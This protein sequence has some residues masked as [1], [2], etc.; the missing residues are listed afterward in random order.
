[1]D[2]HQS[3]RPANGDSDGR[4]SLP[5]R[6][7]AVLA[8]LPK[9]LRIIGGVLLVACGLVGFLPVLGFW[10]VPLGLL[11]LSIDIPWLKP[12]WKRLEALSL[13]LRDRVVR[14]K[15]WRIGE[16][17]V[18]GFGDDRVMSMAAAIAF[19]T[20]FSLAPTLLLVSWIAGVAFG[21][22]ESQQAIIREVGGLIG[23]EGVAR[24]E[25]I[26]R[27]TADQ[28][29]STLVANII[30]IVLLVF[31]ATTVFVEVNTSLNVI[32]RQ[33]GTLPMGIVELLKTRL[34]SFS[35]ILAF[36]FL[37]LVSLAV[38]AALSAASNYIIGID[39][40]F[41]YMLEGINILVSLVITFVMFAMMYRILPTVRVPWRHVWMAALATAILFNFGKT[42]IGFY[43]GQSNVASTYG[44][45]S[46][47]ILILLWVYYSVVIF[48]AGAEFA[49]AYAVVTASDAPIGTNKGRPGD[50]D[51]KLR[52]SLG[53]Y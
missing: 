16:A 10:M 27:T 48:L 26:M 9:P 34:L 51:Q 8:R 43:I 47:V 46:V 17:T 20:V 33:T 25:E 49:K 40:T 21:P 50:A 39:W 12:W 7:R 45:A 37:L 24:L 1:M 4:R 13:R 18:D 15:A 44:A 14:T 6:L 31:G 2:A 36:G 3:D 19:Y 28:P 42:A 41:A 29:R 23:P 52:S 32:W 38:N 11:V 53:Q 35:L 22:E 5:E 30:G